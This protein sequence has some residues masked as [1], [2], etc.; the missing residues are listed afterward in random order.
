MKSTRENMEWEAN[1]FACELLMPHDELIAYVEKIA[2]MRDGKRVVDIEN[3]AEHFQ[4][5]PQMVRVRGAMFGLWED[6]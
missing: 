3:V 6:F 2:E 4:V 1:E 5:S